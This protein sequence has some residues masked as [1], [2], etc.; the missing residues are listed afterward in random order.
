V[1]E[2]NQTF[3][4]MLRNQEGATILKTK[5]IGEI[6]DKEQFIHDALCL[7]PQAIDYHVS[8]H[9]STLFPDRALLE[10]GEALFNIE[11]FARA[12][13]CHLEHKAVIYNQVITH[14]RAPEIG[15]QPWMQPALRMAGIV[16]PGPTEAE[17]QIFER[18]KNAWLEVAWGDSVFDIIVMNW[19]E[20]FGRHNYHYWILAESMERARDLLIEVCKW[21]AE[22]RGEVLVFDSGCWQK[23]A[24][25][26]Q[27]IK[28]STF[29]NLILRGSLKQDIREDLEQFFIARDTYE[30]YNIPWKR[31]ILFV[32]PPGNGK[33]H[34]V[35]AIIN[36]MN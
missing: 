7:P 18:S 31:G 1:D 21:N 34:A 27:A 12:G 25:L 30:T 3:E 17:Q 2:L 20:N 6:M 11:E 22:I 9:L 4:M 26:F 15:N 32:G 19:S 8:L 36:V 24:R 10:G 5:S 14:W 29:D 28:N 23:D 13:Y 35:K 16:V 33:T